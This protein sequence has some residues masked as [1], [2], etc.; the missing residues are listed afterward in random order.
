MD[1]HVCTCVY[2]QSSLP[3]GGQSCRWLPHL[4]STLPLEKVL[5]NLGLLFQLNCLARKSQGPTCVRGSNWTYRCIGIPGFCFVLFCLFVC[6]FVCVMEFSYM[7][8]TDFTHWTIS[9]TPSL[10]SSWNFNQNPVSTPP[11]V[12]HSYTKPQGPHLQMGINVRKSS[13]L[14]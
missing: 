14:F 7:Y 9:T 3:G 12:I 13:L 4:L 11:P 6:Y 10:D 5:L 2:D 8:H 1:V